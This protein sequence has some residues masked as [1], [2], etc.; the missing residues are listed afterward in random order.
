M[1]IISELLNQ[2]SDR[3][4]DH[5]FCVNSAR[6]IVNNQLFVSHQDCNTFPNH[7]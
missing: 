3:N 6:I 1:V 5:P 4:D 2:S 7:V